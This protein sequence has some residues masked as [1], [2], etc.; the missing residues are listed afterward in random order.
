VLRYDIDALEDLRILFE[1]G[2]ITL[3]E[4]K[5]KRDNRKKEMAET[6]RRME[7]KIISKQKLI[8]KLRNLT[9][10]KLKKWKYN[11]NRIRLN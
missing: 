5:D 3:E 11:T 9:K 8:L 1:K 7:W 2:K 10:K 6:I 4:Y